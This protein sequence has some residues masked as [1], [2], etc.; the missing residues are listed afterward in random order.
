MNLDWSKT[1]DVIFVEVLKKN[2]YI[3]IFKDWLPR[4]KYNWQEFHKRKTEALKKKDEKIEQIETNK[5]EKA[6]VIQKTDGKTELVELICHDQVLEE[7]V[8]VKVDLAEQIIKQTPQSAA[9]E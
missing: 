2:C 6:E 8:E 7:V 4:Q 9:L 5:E 1:D 3:G